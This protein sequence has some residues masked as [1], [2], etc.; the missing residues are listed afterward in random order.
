MFLKLP[1]DPDPQVWPYPFKLSYAPMIGGKGE[2]HG[3]RTYSFLS[4]SNTLIASSQQYFNT[5][6]GFKINNSFVVCIEQISLMY[7]PLFI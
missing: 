1:W 7:N 3:F 5:S 4:H 6:L 2:D